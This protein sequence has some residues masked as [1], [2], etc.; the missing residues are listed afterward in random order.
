VDPMIKSH[1]LYQLSYASPWHKLDSLMP[2]RAGRLLA[3]CGNV[4]RNRGWLKL[5]P[6]K[7]RNHPN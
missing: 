1:L 4:K 6:L 2:F 7:C 5:G 3:F